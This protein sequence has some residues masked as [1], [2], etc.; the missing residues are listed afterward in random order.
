MPGKGFQRIGCQG[1]DDELREDGCC[2]S[3]NQALFVHFGLRG[4]M[5][6]CKSSVQGLAA[7]QDERAGVDIK[8]TKLLARAVTFQLRE[9]V[10]IEVGIGELEHFWGNLSWAILF[11]C[12]GIGDEAAKLG[13]DSGSSSLEA[14]V[15]ALVGDI[16]DAM[17]GNLSVRGLT[18][19]RR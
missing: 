3:G 15:T 9:R 11:G 6:H 1:G 19:G 5:I 17:W 10:L 16:V 12:R 14:V 7:E 8:E 4:P 18:S 13:D 2:A